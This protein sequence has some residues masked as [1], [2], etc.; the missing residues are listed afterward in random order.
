MALLQDYGLVFDAVICLLLVVAI[1][2]AVALNRK[3][4]LLRDAKRDMEKLF[5]EFASA[6]NEAQGGLMALKEGSGT[7][8]QALAKNVSDACRLADEMAFL[9]KKGNEIA[10]RLEVQIAAS[11]KASQVVAPLR[12]EMPQ[13]PQPVKPPHSQAPQAPQAQPRAPETLGA[14]ALE[15]GALDAVK[16]RAAQGL[17]DGLADGL[18][19]KEGA[20][21]GIAKLAKRKLSEA[22]SDL[23]R[24]LQ[25]IR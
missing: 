11:R 20:P 14:A 19:A 1:G 18:A 13:A 6:T 9:V 16:A 17:A 2:Y 23:M 10:D 15:S 12:K 4:T 7:A 8:G 25:A 22:D 24:T 3:L 5:A 21:R